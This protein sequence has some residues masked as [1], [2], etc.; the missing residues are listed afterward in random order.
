MIDLVKRTRIVFWITVIC[1][2][3]LIYFAI[4]GPLQ[5]ELKESIY[6]NITEISKSKLSSFEN[7]VSGDIQ[8]SGGLSSRTMIKNKIVEYNQGLIE[9]DELTEYTG[10]KYND[11]A[12]VLDNIVSAKRVVDHQVIASYSNPNKNVDMPMPE[13]KEK[14]PLSYDFILIGGDVFL[15]TVSPITLEK[16]ELGVDIVFFDLTDQISSLNNKAYTCSIISQTEYDN[17][18]KSGSA[19]LTQGGLLSQKDFIYYVKPLGGSYYFQVKADKKI[20]FYDLN[21]LTLNILISYFIVFAGLYFTVYFY[22]VRYAKNRISSVEKS[23]D[24]LQS[25]V[26]KDK[27]TGL[28]TKAYLEYWNS[29]IGKNYSKCCLVMA[30]IDNFK[31]IIQGNGH[32]VGDEVIKTVSEVIRSSVREIDA[33]VR[34][35]GDE[36][37]ILFADQD[38]NDALNVI[39]DIKTRLTGIKSFIFEISISFGIGII[40][41]GND[42]NSAL[43]MADQRLNEEKNSRSIDWLK[44]LG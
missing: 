36:F 32:L 40:D 10:P 31:M 34:F 33:V 7:A 8:V 18:E 38:E 5:S 23:R 6:Q 42:F 14:N 44:I 37:L 21:K 22:I 43:Q 26:Y 9:M 19:A 41:S 29:N 3:L 15:R 13:I 30:D 28:F 16:N 2:S 24:E 17:L 39:K 20:A 12:S 35:G 4:F 1:V 27:M 25:L 11:G